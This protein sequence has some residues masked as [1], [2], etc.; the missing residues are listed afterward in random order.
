M[1]SEAP[2]GPVHGQDASTVPAWQPPRLETQLLVGA[3]PQ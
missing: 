3:S 1:S 2:K